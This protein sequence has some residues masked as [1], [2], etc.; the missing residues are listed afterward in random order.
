[1]NYLKQYE[2]IKAIAECRSITLAAEKLGIAQS[3]LS[4]YVKKLENDI[5]AELLDR[6][7]EPI[8]LTKSGVY[9][10]E[11][12]RKMLSLNQDLKSRLREL[13]LS[14]CATI[15]VGVGPSRGPYILPAILN[16]YRKQDS[17]TNI[18]I[19]ELTTDEI[20]QR[21][22]KNELDIAVSVF[23]ADLL[24]IEH[25]KLFRERIL[26]CENSKRPCNCPILPGKG[27]LL[28]DVMNNIIENNDA[29]SK[30]YIEVQNAETA[31]A[32]VKAGLGFTIVQ[33]YFEEFS[34]G[35]ELTYSELP[36]S[37]ILNDRIIS[38]L[39]RKGRK[40]TKEELL[41]IECAQQALGV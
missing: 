36:D 12:G 40:L 1:M 32:L 28:R 29:Y 16:L 3:A 27:Q 9:F 31:V 33:S 22:L 20:T 5:G 18:E 19:Y 10:L 4:R 2:Y 15:R 23:D 7:S 38:L 24:H 35:D 37:I 6:K 17:K 25:V 11:I 39:Y 26:L 21:L 8:S 34:H 41:F 13:Q 14:E 30:N